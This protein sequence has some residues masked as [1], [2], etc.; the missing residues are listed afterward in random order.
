[1]ITS[2]AFKHG[3]RGEK[4]PGADAPHRLVAAPPL[5]PLRGETTKLPC[6]VQLV[7]SLYY[8]LAHSDAPDAGP[9]VIRNYLPLGFTCKI[10]RIM[11]EI[12]VLLSLFAAVLGLSPFYFLYRL[13]PRR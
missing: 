9:D 10:Y 3:R 2:G 11:I 4:L 5:P 1:M 8:L 6:E 7:Y 13:P 12:G